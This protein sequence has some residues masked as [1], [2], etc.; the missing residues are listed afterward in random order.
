[1]SRRGIAYNLAVSPYSEKVFYKG[2][3]FV[4]YVFSSQL[5][6]TNFQERIEENRQKINESLSK[7]F[8]YGIENNKLADIKLYLSVE[9]R[10]FLLRDREKEYTCQ[11]NIKL[12]GLKLT[13]ESCS[14]Q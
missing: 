8:G 12:D 9:K 14:A 3:D 4:E 10:G 5:Y 7:R 6:K 13:S 1:M 11:K 2:G